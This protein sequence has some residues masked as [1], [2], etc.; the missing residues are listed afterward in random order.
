M[1]YIFLPL[2]KFIWALLLSL[3][4][5]FSYII[6]FLISALLFIILIIWQFK[7]PNW[8][9]RWHKELFSYKRSS[10]RFDNDYDLHISPYYKNINDE[11][12]HFKSYYHYIWNIK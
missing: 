3:L 8:Y 11:T 6:W 2:L 1:K 4:F 7:I 5:V 12:I 9:K 10:S